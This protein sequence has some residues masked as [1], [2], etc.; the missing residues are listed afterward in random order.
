MDGGSA[1]LSIVALVLGITWLVFPF[2]VIWKLNDVIAA[3]R[4][5]KTDKSPPSPPVKTA[6]TK[7]PI[8][9]YNL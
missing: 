4:D 2:I 8:R 9:G 7:T 5:L 3:V 1:L 6:P